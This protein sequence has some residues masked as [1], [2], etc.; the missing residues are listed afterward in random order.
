MKIR[1]NMC[2]SYF[3]KFKNDLNDENGLN[4]IKLKKVKIW[5][6]LLDI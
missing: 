5:F 2:H 3:I 6:I 4:G 1:I